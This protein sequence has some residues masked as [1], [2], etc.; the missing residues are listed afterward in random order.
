MAQELNLGSSGRPIDK[1]TVREHEIVHLVSSGMSNREIAK[2]L[3]I[4]EETV[5]RHISNIFDKLGCSNRVEMVQM[6][7]GRPIGRIL[8]GFVCGLCEREVLIRNDDT[9]PVDL[10]LV[11]NKEGVE[12]Q[13]LSCLCRTCADRVRS[14]F[15][16][17]VEKCKAAA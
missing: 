11:T 17:A 16:Q 9:L 14:A 8:Q 7:A 15:T 13:A 10:A 1:L 6:Y 2:Q 12:N 3:N 5:K 4:S